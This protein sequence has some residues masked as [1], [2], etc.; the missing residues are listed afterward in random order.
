MHILQAKL[1]YHTDGLLY[2]NGHLEATSD[3]RSVP[4]GEKRRKGRPK[5]IPHS[6]QM[7]PAR[8]PVEEI[9]GGVPVEDAPLNI[10]DNENG[11]TA[12]E[13]DINPEPRKTTRKRKRM[14]DKNSP[15]DAIVG[16]AKPVGPGL[17]QAKPVGSGSG[18]AKPVGSGLGQAKP[19]GS[20]LGQA[21][22][23]GPGLGQAKPPK[24]KPRTQEDNET[25]IQKPLG[26]Q[27]KK[28]R[29][30]CNHEIVFGIHY[31][32][33]M[34]DQYAESVR[35]KKSRVEIDPDYVV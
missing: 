20:G 24:K 13:E 10:I 27:C 11:G 30:G 17:G 29:G 15:V 5:K 34:W 12:P 31:N 9:L 7:S 32:K 21:K 3:V 1:C 6:L 14:G 25:V 23:V 28:K 22:P 26:V 33:K 2:V 18:Q 4:L 19:V 35:S 8:N 16:Q